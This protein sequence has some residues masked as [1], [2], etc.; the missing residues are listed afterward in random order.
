MFVRPFKKERLLLVDDEAMITKMTQQTLSRLGYN[1]TTRTSPVEA[2]EFFKVRSNDIDLVI[3]D[4]TMPNITGDKLSIE[5]MKIRR[6]LDEPK[7]LS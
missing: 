5:L 7:S 4:M 2:L 3:T 1:V 6:V